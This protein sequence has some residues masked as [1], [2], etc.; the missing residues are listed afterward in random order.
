MENVVK[1]ATY[2]QIR[3]L[4]DVHAATPMTIRLLEIWT[5]GTPRRVKE[6]EAN[7]ELLPL[8]RRLMPQLEDA[9]EMTGTHSHLAPHEILQEAGLPLRL[10]S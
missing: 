5:A 9:Q 7:G 4:G 1:N 10:G 6:L 8:F 2:E 3:H